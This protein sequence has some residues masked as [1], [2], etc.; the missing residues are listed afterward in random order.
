VKLWRPWQLRLL[1]ALSAALFA[2]VIAIW[3]RSY[4]STDI[5]V[6]QP[7]IDYVLHA[8]GIGWGRGYIVVVYEA[9]THVGVPRFRFESLPPK[10]MDGGWMS[11]DQIFHVL[12]IRMISR[13]QTVMINVPVREV[14]LYMPCAWAAALF[15]ILP[16]DWLLR[17]RRLALIEKRKAAGECIRCGYDMR[18]TPERCPECGAPAT[19]S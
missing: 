9:V 17:R 2:A 13:S 11:A 12:G 18:A 14:A 7:R 1:T 16:A 15:A 6:L 5:A 8:Y 10:R 3:V 19:D 4:F